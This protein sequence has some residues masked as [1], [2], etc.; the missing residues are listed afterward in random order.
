MVWR[1]PVLPKT[2]RLGVSALPHKLQNCKPK[3]GRGTKSTIT[4]SDSP[5]VILFGKEQT[6][7]CGTFGY[8]GSTS[9]KS[10]VA[11]RRRR[12]REGERDL[13]RERERKVKFLPPPRHVTGGADQRA[14]THADTCTQ[15][16]RHAGRLIIYEQGHLDALA[17]PRLGAE[18]I[19]LRGRERNRDTLCVGR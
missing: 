4:V 5:L 9:I 7:D 18:S 17:R 14:Q 6:N 15:A 3:Q 16:R 12:K 13:E 10:L 11:C 2:P 8:G 19:K 1:S